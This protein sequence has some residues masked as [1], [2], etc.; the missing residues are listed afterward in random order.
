MYRIKEI[1]DMCGLSI[2]ALRHYD[3]IGLLKPASVTE[4]GY[5]L[6]DEES[7][8]RISLIL[9]FRELGF[10]LEDIRVMIDSPDFDVKQ[11]VEEQIRMLHE[12]RERID[13]LIGFARRVNEKGV[14]EMDF[15]VFDDRK[16][17][18]YREDAKN[19]WGDTEAYE[20]YLKKSRN[21]T[22]SEEKMIGMGIMDIMKEFG[23][24]LGTDPSADSVRKPVIKLKSYIT[25]NF[26]ECTDE[27]LLGLSEMYAAGGEM[28]ENIDAH[29]GKGTGI[30]I[31][32]AVREYLKSK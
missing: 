10:R 1:S 19:R 6:Y 7:L 3:D 25:E 24:V 31:K 22:G 28:T 29:A 21:R 9:V 26:Y 4:A 27:I 17:K 23:E 13:S 2:R 20:E 8:R 30:F 18:K 32:E 5:R 12:K 11:A 14:A 16:L 15:S